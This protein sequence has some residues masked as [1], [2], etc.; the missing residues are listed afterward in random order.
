MD[1][2]IALGL[3]LRMSELDILINAAT[4]EALQLQAK[5]YGSLL[6]L[7]RSYKDHV[8]AVH[9]WGVTDDLSW[10]S[11]HYPLLFDKD[12][13]PKPAYFAIADPMR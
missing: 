3:T 7:F 4:E 2:V 1:K 9:T 11:S 8:A 5:R 13:L 10:K 6:E 12:G